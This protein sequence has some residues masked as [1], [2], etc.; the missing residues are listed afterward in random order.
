MWGRE[1]TLRKEVNSHSHIRPHIT[2][3]I[4]GMVFTLLTKLNILTSYERENQT[5]FTQTVH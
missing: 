1:V 5:Y 2:L 4:F 3:T